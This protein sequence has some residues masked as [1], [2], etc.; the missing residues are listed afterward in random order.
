ML[1]Y[2]NVHFTLRGNKVHRLRHLQEE[3]KCSMSVSPRMFQF[4]TSVSGAQS[5]IDS[6][7]KNCH[8]KSSKYG[9]IK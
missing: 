6:R 8:K 9:G 3:S 2:F 7:L 5:T 4:N 1:K